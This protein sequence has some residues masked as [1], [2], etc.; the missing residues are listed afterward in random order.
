MPPG[1]EDGD[2]PLARIKSAGIKVYRMTDGVRVAENTSN[3]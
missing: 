1:W 2:S 3:Q